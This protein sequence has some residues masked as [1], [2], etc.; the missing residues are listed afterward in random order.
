[1]TKRR[2]MTP[3]R[4]ARI[5]KAH[6]CKC[7]RC[8]EGF[9]DGEAVEFDHKLALARG[10]TDDD[11]N[12]GPCHVHCHKLKTFGGSTKLG[13]DIFEIAKTKRL[14]KKAKGKKEK[15]H[16]WAKRPFGNSKFKKKLDGTVERRDAGK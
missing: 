15:K 4:K 13:S 5:L 6:D 11:E 2:A 7:W 1:M 10:G 14:A 16:N 9:A 12:V 8:K 3:A